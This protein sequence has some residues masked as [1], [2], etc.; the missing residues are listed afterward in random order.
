MTVKAPESTRKPSGPSTKGAK[1]APEC[2]KVSMSLQSDCTNLTLVD[3]TPRGEGTKATVFR[4]AAKFSEVGFHGY[5][6]HSF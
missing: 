6:L 2:V 1:S 3:G 4:F 5:A